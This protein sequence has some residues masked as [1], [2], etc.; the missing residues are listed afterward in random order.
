MTSPP[1]PV[2]QTRFE[3]LLADN[4]ARLRELEAQGMAPNPLGLLHAR[5]D[6]LI[7]AIVGLSGGDLRIGLHIRI[8]FEEKLAKEFGEAAQA[9]RRAILTQGSHMTPGEIREIARQSGQ[10]GKL[11]PH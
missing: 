4:Q 6:A 8:Q 1:L 5:I 2:M 11:F 10:Y 7:D 3:Q 9:G